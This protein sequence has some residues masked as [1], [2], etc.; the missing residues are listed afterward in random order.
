MK[1]ILALTLLAA[2]SVSLYG[3]GIVQFQNRD[4]TVTPNV[5]APIY[6]D[7]TNGAGLNGSDTTL[8]A[9]LLGGPS[10]A[11]AAFIPGSL[12]SGSTGAS[13]AGTLSL[14]ASPST[15]AT[16][17]TFRTGAAAGY[18]AV[19]TD[20]ARDTLQPFST[21]V[22]VQVVAWNGGYNDWA[23]A[24]AAWLAGTPGVKIGASNP[25]FVTTPSGATDPNLTKLVGLSSF[26]IVS[27]VPEPS[28][29]ALVGLGA[30]ALM[31]F[32]RRK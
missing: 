20:A 10:T 24:Y 4:T 28:T 13:T 7:A 31:I 12:Y 8:R 32:R 19:G 5:V 18:V 30:A 16:W 21:Q 11:T 17:A 6:V 3:Q 1:K 25:L 14:L 2:A 26:A 23:S 15:G 27:N 9:A 22:E 29:F